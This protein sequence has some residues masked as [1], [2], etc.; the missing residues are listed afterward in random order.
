MSDYMTPDNMVAIREDSRFYH[1][2]LTSLLENATT[3]A[4]GSW[5]DKFSDLS[6][7]ASWKI[8]GHVPSA[9]A[10]L[11]K[12][13]RLFS[14]GTACRDV[15][16]YLLSAA[17]WAGLEVSKYKEE[18]VRISINRLLSMC[19]GKYELGE[20]LLKE[21][22]E[23]DKQV[24][25]DYHEYAIKTRLLVFRK[26]IELA[27]FPK[28]V[29]DP[30]KFGKGNVPETI[31]GQYVK[32]C[33]VYAPGKAFSTSTLIPQFSEEADGVRGY[34]KPVRR[35]NTGPMA[36][37]KTIKRCLKVLK[38][39]GWVTIKTVGTYRSGLARF[40]TPNIFEVIKRLEIHEIS[41]AIS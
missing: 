16:S 1:Q 9:T 24:P 12:S 21:I 33:G 31:Y 32:G 34:N 28:A 39:I 7:G 15:N 35:Q 37:D 8:V 3:V 25:E 41:G 5:L 10:S 13:Y 2:A 30:W 14:H 4:D 38:D 20:L 17:V 29:I 40:V 18:A 11:E 22:S 36:S 6:N 26:C 23:N 19:S 27:L